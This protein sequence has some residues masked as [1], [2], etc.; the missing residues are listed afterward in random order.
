MKYIFRMGRMKGKK[1]MQIKEL[2]GGQ[3][4]GSGE[5]YH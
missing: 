3:D 4:I 5:V 1:N 2:K